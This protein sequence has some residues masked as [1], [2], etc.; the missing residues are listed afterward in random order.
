[1]KEA[2]TQ[3]ASFAPRMNVLDVSAL[4][5]GYRDRPVLREVTFAVSPGELWAILGP[6][7]AGKSTLLRTCLGLHPFQAGQITVLGKPIER[8]SRRELAQTM[9]WVPQ[10]FDPAD[11]FTG[12]ELVL[13]GRS[14]HLGIWG[15]PTRSDATSALSLMRDLEIEDLAPRASNALSGGERRLLVLARALL[16]DPRILMLDEPTAFL[17]L[18]HQV[19]VLSRIKARVKKGLAAL[20][21][22]HDVNHAVAFADKVLL[23]KD[24]A[25]L[26]H[27]P[28]EAT[29]NAPVL[30]RLFD[31][32]ITSATAADGQRLFAPRFGRLE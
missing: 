20:A 12:L 30:E 32:P 17:D 5:A 13:M 24:G 22:V 21:V 11:G 2:A 9:A 8:W 28:P 3:D 6:N 23:V 18:K 29:L 7:G 16:Q 15:L 19:D 26:A 31:L 4:V 25:V 14:P 10:S 27:G 1:M